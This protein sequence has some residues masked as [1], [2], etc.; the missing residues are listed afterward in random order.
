MREIK[1]TQD[2]QDV[3]KRGENIKVSDNRAARW[4]RDGKAKEPGQEVEPPKEPEEVR[5]TAPKPKPKG[6]PK[7]K[8]KGK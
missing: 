1:L 4:I 5:P 6:K 2:E 3:G 8:A 7:G